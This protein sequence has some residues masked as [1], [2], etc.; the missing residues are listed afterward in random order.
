MH[1]FISSNGSDSLLKGCVTAGS[2]N[3]HVSECINLRT[4]SLTGKVIAQTLQAPGNANI[5]LFS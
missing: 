5:T 3:G 1:I 2:L 4:C